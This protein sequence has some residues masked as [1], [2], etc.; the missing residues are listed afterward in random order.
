[1]TANLSVQDAVQK[2]KGSNPAFN[3]FVTIYRKVVGHG[4]SLTCLN[5]Q[6]CCCRRRR[7]QSSPPLRSLAAQFTTSSSSSPP[8]SHFP[9]PSAAEEQSRERAGSSSPPTPQ[10]TISQPA[11]GE[12]GKFRRSGGARSE[13]DSNRRRQVSK[14]GREEGVCVCVCFLSR[15]HHVCLEL[16]RQPARPPPAVSHGEYTRTWCGG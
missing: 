1:M 6:F 7:R 5:V 10:C 16:S 15:F 13:V 12:G 4:E 11:A 2:L 14:V 9:L 3:F 8:S